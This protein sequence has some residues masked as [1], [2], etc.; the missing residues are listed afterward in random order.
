[1]RISQRLASL[2]ASDT[3]RLADLATRKR[4][5]GEVVYD[6]SAGRA[7]EDTPGPICERAIHALRTGDTHQTMAQGTTAYR[8]ACANKLARENDITAD[9]A[10]EVIATMG[11]K[12]GLLCALLATIDPGD[13]VIVEDPGFVSYGPTVRLAGGVER[14]V[15]L[16]PENGFRWNLA[17]LE[18]AVT[19]RTRALIF[20]SPHNPCGTVHSRSELD[21]LA[22][23]AARHD[24]VVITDEIY[25]RVVW[26]GRQH[27][28]LASL[29]EAR[30]RTISLMGLTKA[31]A[32]GGWR[33]GFA[34]A[35]P[36]RIEAMTKVQQHLITSVS[37]FVQAGASAAFGE[38]ASAEVKQLWQTWEKRCFHVADTL[39]AVPGLTCPRP[40]GGF[41]V[42]IDHRT[43]DGSS[44]DWAERLLRE[45]GAV[46]VP[47]SAFGP[48]GEGFLRMTS[49]KSDDELAA[50]LER[51]TAAFSSP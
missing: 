25:E 21:G 38:P 41:Y 17:E 33:V 4:E 22:A 44:L 30:Q 39:D 24:L 9:P 29:P 34:L 19:P 40:E 8:A 42:W 31:F 35:A 3:V 47:G 26:A 6:F 12:E 49:V 10:T 37:S 27:V 50:G 23:L 16:R 14:P 32:M 28:S 45:F 48:Q 43:F 36:A 2:P 7:C 1:M 20:C 13:E 5:R 18:Q 15:P 11:N 51:L 46:V